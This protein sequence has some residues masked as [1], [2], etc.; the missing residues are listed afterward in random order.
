MP[1]LLTVYMVLPTNHRPTTFPSCRGAPAENS[2]N[3]CKAGTRAVTVVE[4]IVYDKEDGKRMN[5]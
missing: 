2:I 1:L 3:Q 5:N 4:S